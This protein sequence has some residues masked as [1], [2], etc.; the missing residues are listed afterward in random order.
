[1]KRTHVVVVTATLA[2]VAVIGAAPAAAS[3]L[4]PTPA[5]TKPGAATANVEAKSEAAVDGDFAA[6]AATLGVTT[7]RLTA[8]LVA[9][10]TS[11]AAST[12]V[13]PDA[14]V[15]AVAANLG[16]PVSQVR[17]ALAPMFIKPAGTGA[18]ES[19]QDSTEKEG[20]DGPEN[21]PF[22]TDAAAAALA[23]TLGVD[24]GKAKAALAAVVALAS[25]AGGVDPTSQP[26]GE[27]AAS[28]GVSPDRLIAALTELKRSLAN[29]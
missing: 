10:K 24:Q 1:M 11:L 16:L 26:F 21:S 15:A 3:G 29:G 2:G 14:F 23:A 25:A 9:A 18:E 13:T 12:G 28:L 7:D 27:I 19:K 4:T 5:A 22:T 8:A 6:L 20:V 17:D